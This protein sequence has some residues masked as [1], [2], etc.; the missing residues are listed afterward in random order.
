MAITLV[1]EDGTGKSNANSYAS[2]AN[3]D[4]YHDAHLY[5]TD[6]TGATDAT[7]DKA[8]AMATRQLDEKF[9][10][11][12]TKESETNALQWP[13]HGTTDR[14]GWAIDSDEIPQDLIN[15]TAELARL[16]IGTD[17]TAESDT[18]GY[19]ELKVAS[20]M[21]KIDK[22]DV[23]NVMSDTVTAMVSPFGSST[24]SGRLNLVRA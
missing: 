9:R 18:K 13:R 12:G 21:M 4:A 8:L 1:V 23:P 6:W 7:K 5:A 15:A 22:S 19:S 14:G 3:G 24:E 2:I 10:W 16:L 20:L 17:R 11:D